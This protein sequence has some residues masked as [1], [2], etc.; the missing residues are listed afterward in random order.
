MIEKTR[1]EIPA[2][3]PIRAFFQRLT[4]R[5]MGQLNLRDR[6]TIQYITNLLTEFIQIE[7]MYRMKDK[8]GR[9]LQ[10][11]FEMLTQASNAMSP[12][13]RRDCYKHLGDLTLFNLG[14]FPESLTYGHRTVSPD[15]YAETGRRSYTIVAEMDSST[16]GTIVYRKLSEQFEQCVVGLNWVKV[17][18]NDPF[19]QYMFR[20]FDVT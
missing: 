4:E 15:Y 11:V 2:D 20:E 10:Y 16:R 18:I 12:S 17:Y 7:N 1:H 14:L 13:M 5:G 8:S 6:D 19:Y 9:Q 3:H